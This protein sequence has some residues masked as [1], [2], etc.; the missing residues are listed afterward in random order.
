MVYLLV[1]ILMIA[2]FLP[3]LRRFAEGAGT[4]SLNAVAGGPAR[5]LLLITV[6]FVFYE[7]AL[8][9]HFP[10]THDLVNDW[11]HHAHRF[12]IF[13]LG[14]FAAKHDGFWRSVDRALPA[15]AVLVVLIGGGRLYLR[16]EHWDY[17]QSV[18]NGPVATVLLTLYA[19]SFIVFCSALR[20]GS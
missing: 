12:T 14:Y 20:S 18:I 19:W 15:A 6:P 1:Y 8:S 17:Y 5:L 7:A 13:I 10:T 9:P 11:A 4:S 2:P 3:L 16:A